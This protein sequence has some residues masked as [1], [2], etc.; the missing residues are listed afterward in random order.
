MKRQFC[1]SLTSA[2][3]NKTY[4]G[5]TPSRDGHNGTGGRFG[6]LGGDSDGGSV[7]VPVEAGADLP[8]GD[9]VLVGVAVPVSGVDL[10]D[11]VGRSSVGV[12]QGTGNDVVVGSSIAIIYNNFH[13]F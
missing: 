1:F 11:G 13:Y 7:G 2:G 10:R 5:G 6:S 8:Q 12:L 9:V 4:R 3:R